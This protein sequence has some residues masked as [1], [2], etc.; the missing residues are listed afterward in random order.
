MLKVYVFS[1]ENELIRVVH[2]FKK[3]LKN[4][5]LASMYEHLLD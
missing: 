3:I 5:S 4:T 1:G 2:Y